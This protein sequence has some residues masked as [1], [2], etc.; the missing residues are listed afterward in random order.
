M[1]TAVR[2][3]GSALASSIDR[4]SALGVWGAMLGLA[5][6]IAAY[7]I[8]ITSRYFLND[9]TGWANDLVSYLLAISVF[10]AMPRVTAEGGHVAITFLITNLPERPARLLAI[11]LALLA[12]IVCLSVAVISGLETYRQFQQGLVTM[13][14]YPIP[15]WWI[16]IFITF[17]FLGSGWYF[18]RELARPRGQGSSIG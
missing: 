12:G 6:I 11:V 2:H 13:A 9:P 18:L 1:N 8:E 17:G 16:S 14:R 5:G 3:V 4:I 15:K 7:L 10:L